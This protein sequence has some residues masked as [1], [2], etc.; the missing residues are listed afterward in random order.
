MNAA[1]KAQLGR[2]VR[3]VLMTL[4]SSAIVVN[5]VNAAAVRYPLLGLAVGLLEAFYRSAV[6]TV[7]APPVV[8]K[9]TW[10]DRPPGPGAP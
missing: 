1:A 8:V 4:F 9:S 2:I 10:S 3:L 5:L 6:P 7:P